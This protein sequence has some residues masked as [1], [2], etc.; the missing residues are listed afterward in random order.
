MAKAS[1]S[2]GK[3]WGAAIIGYGDFHYKYESGREG[4]WFL[5]GFSP[6][7]ANITLY[8]G[9]NIEEESDLLKK[10]GKHKLG[11]GCLYIKQLSDVDEKMLYSVFQKV[12]K[13][14]KALEKK[15]NS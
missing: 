2:T 1:G 8:L 13:T 9:Y 14:Q 6:R 11:K 5:I 10:L 7:K 15:M 4:D 3:M 12:V